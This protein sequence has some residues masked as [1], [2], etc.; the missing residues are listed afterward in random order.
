MN[1]EWLS[2]IDMIWATVITVALNAALLAWVLTRR[3]ATILQGAPDQAWWRDLRL[4][5][6][7]VVLVQIGLYWALR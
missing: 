6:V 1:F 4:W 3:R 7:P 2:G 5:M